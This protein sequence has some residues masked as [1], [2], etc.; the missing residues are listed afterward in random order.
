M[1]GGYYNAKPLHSREHR[2][3]EGFLSLFTSYFSQFFSPPFP[4]T[5]GIPLVFGIHF[6]VH[7]NIV[8]K[9]AGF[10]VKLCPPSGFATYQLHDLGQVT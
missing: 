2:V 10:G 9:S 3:E 7:C 5:P 1:G 4:V 6:Y 8:V